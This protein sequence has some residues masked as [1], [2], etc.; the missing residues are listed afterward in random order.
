M[1]V[2]LNHRS[3]LLSLVLFCA[4][5]AVPAP[6]DAPGGE[7]VTDT[8]DAGGCLEGYIDKDGLWVCL[9]NNSPGPISYCSDKCDPP[10]NCL[11][12]EKGISDCIYRG[13]H[14]MD[15]TER[16]DCGPNPATTSHTHPYKWTK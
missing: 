9:G 8:V 7:V 16:F 14:E 13:I 3:L 6:P 1:E 4:L 15:P 12:K 2:V 10:W 5:G 11:I